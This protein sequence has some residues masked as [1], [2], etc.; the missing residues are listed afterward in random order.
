MLQNSTL[1]M[2][3]YVYIYIC[4]LAHFSTLLVKKRHEWTRFHP[5]DLFS[6]RHDAFRPVEAA[7]ITWPYIYTHTNL[8]AYILIH[9][10]S[11][12]WDVLPGTCVALYR[13]SL[14]LLHIFF[15]MLH[16][17]AKLYL[18]VQPFWLTYIILVLDFLNTV[19]ISVFQNDDQP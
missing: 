16:D 15:L 14:F 5:S 10:G 3:I 13:I 9:Q 2:R 17:I 18:M 1:H 4:A 7:L 19:F 8:H 11:T 12:F 6:N